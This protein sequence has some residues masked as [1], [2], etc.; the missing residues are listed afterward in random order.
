MDYSID[1]DIITEISEAE[2]GE[3]INIVQYYDCENSFV[4]DI[5]LTRAC[6]L[7]IAYIIIEMLENEVD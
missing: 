5:C 1:S 2:D 6:A 4:D 7:E 3:F